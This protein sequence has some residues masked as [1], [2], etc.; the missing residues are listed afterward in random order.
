MKS[1]KLKVYEGTGIK[2][3]P[4]VSLEG[5]WLIELG[6]EIGTRIQVECDKYLLVIKTE[7]L[8]NENKEGEFAMADY[9]TMYLQLFT[10]QTEAI[11]ILQQAQQRTEEM[12]MCSPDPA[13]LMLYT[14]MEEISEEDYPGTTLLKKKQE[15]E[16]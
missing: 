1:R 8:S 13:V 6:F 2:R 12:Y 7:E 5:K 15:G 4:K 10:A 14:S 9:K 16:T 11:E 3:V